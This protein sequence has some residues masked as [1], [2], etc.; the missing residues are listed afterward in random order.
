MFMMF[1]PTIFPIPISPSPF[2][3]AITDATISGT[4]TRHD[5]DTND[6]F[7]TPKYSATSTA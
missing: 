2:N 1:E 5:S 3:A 6:H 4:C 7:A